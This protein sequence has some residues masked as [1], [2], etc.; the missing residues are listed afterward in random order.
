MP[1][2]LHLIRGARACGSPAEAIKPGKRMV[3]QVLPGDNQPLPFVSAGSS[4]S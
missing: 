4:L 1:Y 3:D 2:A